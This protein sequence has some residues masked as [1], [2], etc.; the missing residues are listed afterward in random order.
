MPPAASPSRKPRASSQARIAA[1][2]DATRA[3]LAENGTGS[4]SIYAVAERADMP[5][6]SVYHFFPACPRCCRH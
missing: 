4:L 3:L 1:I 6:S 2:L 5:P